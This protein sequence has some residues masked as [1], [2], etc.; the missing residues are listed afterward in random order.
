MCK[1][2]CLTMLVFVFLASSSVEALTV[3]RVRKT[4]ENTTIDKFFQSLVLGLGFKLADSL[5][6]TDTTG[7]Q[8]AIEQLDVEL[9]SMSF[10]L[11]EGAEERAKVE[12]DP[13]S[14]KITVS[15]LNGEFDL[16]KINYISQKAR[17]WATVRGRRLLFEQELESLRRAGFVRIDIRVL[18]SIGRVTGAHFSG[19]LYE[20]E[21]GEMT[22]VENTLTISAN[23]P[24]CPRGLIH[25]MARKVISK[26]SDQ[27]L[28]TLDSKVRDIMVHEKGNFL[29]LAKV[30]GE[31]F[32]SGN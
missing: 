22:I 14:F 2:I 12:L 25:K 8:K 10:I 9:V 5:E 4:E 6:N 1:K 26:K 30:V 32:L 28:A 3:T 31:R 15:P 13:D 21:V 20:A 19:E 29:E 24:G 18:S 16:K 27:A 11:L 17:F 7:I 23:V